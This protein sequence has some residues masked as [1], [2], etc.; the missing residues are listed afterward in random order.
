M[1]LNEAVTHPKNILVNPGYKIK[2]YVDPIAEKSGKPS[3]NFG[4][5]PPAKPKLPVKPANAE[6]FR[7]PRPKMVT[8]VPKKEKTQVRQKESGVL[9]KMAQ[10][11]LCCTL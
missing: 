6:L 2:D 3:F 4:D 10:S 9:E 11:E 1:K 8:V 5:T 7:V